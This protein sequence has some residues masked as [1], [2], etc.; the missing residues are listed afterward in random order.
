MVSRFKGIRYGL[1]FVVVMVSI[2][3]AGYL[4]HGDI[5]EK[6]E[7]AL[8]N[9][10]A[11]HRLEEVYLHLDRDVVLPGE[12]LW[13]K[14]YLFNAPVGEDQKNSGILTL[15]LWNRE[16]G[17][18]LT[19][20]Y[21]MEEDAAA[22]QLNIPDTLSSGTY[23]L[24]AYT[25]AMKSSPGGSFYKRRLY[26]QGNARRL[27]MEI[28][29]SDT[30]YEPG[31]EADAKIFV[32]NRYDQKIRQAKVQYRVEAAGK[33][34]EKGE[35]STNEE[36]FMR[37]A[38][39]LPEDTALHP[40]VLYAYAHMAG[41]RYGSS[42][43]VPS[44]TLDRDIQFFPES[45][46]LLKGV[47]N[48]VAFKATGHF[49]HPIGVAGE[50]MD[51]KGN[52]VRRFESGHA[53]TG[54]FNLPGSNRDLKIRITEPY[55][56][57]RFFELPDP[58]K[59]GCQINLKENGQERVTVQL[60]AAGNF[61]GKDL[62]LIAHMDGQVQWS[63]SFTGS[64][65]QKLTIPTRDLPMGVLTLTV[66][67]SRLI[68]LAERLVFVNKHKRLFVEVTADKSAYG[69]KEKV[70]LD[71]K[72]T[73]RQGNPS[74][75][76]LSMGVINSTRMANTRSFP[77]MP[78]YR[79]LNREIRGELRNPDAYLDFTAEADT[80]L[81]YLL[82]TQ[83]WRRYHYKQMLSNVRQ[84]KKDRP[85]ITGRVLK[86]KNRGA[87]DAT[88]ELFTPRFKIRKE[89]LIKL[90]ESEHTPAQLNNPRY[91]RYVQVATDRKGFF[92]ISA[93]Q[94]KEVIDTGKVM[95]RAAGTNG[96]GEVRI[97]LNPSA[98][99]KKV[100][101]AAPG[102]KDAS[103]PLSP[104]PAGHLQ[105]PDGQKV[106]RN[107]SGRVF[108]SAGGMVD[109]IQVTLPDASAENNGGSSS[110]RK[111]SKGSMDKE[112]SDIKSFEGLV[113]HISTC[114][115]I[116]G[117]RIFLRGYNSVK[118]NSQGATVVVDGFSL[119][120]DLGHNL[121][122]INNWLSNK[123]IKHV[124]VIN[125]P[126]SAM[127][128]VS[129]KQAQGG[130]VIIE[131]EKD[132]R[133]TISSGAGVNGQ[134]LVTIEGYTI[135]KEFYSPDYGKAKDE[136]EKL[137]LRSTLYWNPRIVIDDSGR[138]TVTFYTSDVAMNVLVTINGRKGM[139][140]GSASESFQVR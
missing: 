81:D 30:L 125:N 74:P 54:V 129:G 116:R 128:Y 109:Q 104:F 21:R 140:L 105:D 36:G 119:G 6:V 40:V 26:V 113:Q 136:A 102:L 114:G 80:A 117:S 5:P 15:E 42:K 50:V 37:V 47:S 29:Y 99:S 87:E 112:V 49:G 17:Q 110:N 27:S 120:K 92:R 127:K 25:G 82:M 132:T 108:G 96:K 33:K 72:V 60:K 3:T 91:F 126:A 103:Q 98:K 14:A 22:G 59:N 88:V 16:G 55:K 131:T 51:E 24:V 4:P 11:S 2:L 56:N 53:G 64:Q 20:Y 89:M 57:P 43:A 18:M 38:H 65:E 13:F 68:P 121:S 118:C 139:K 76:E 46:N 83:G 62:T 106:N 12:T 122:G 7:K 75:A 45:G 77:S 28:V 90:L 32:K 84:E 111:K 94:F 48:R 8:R 134:D 85:F 41:Q 86:S 66:F 115:Q 63:Q 71:I 70:K 124:E 123:K 39:S 19:H 67:D 135:A 138:G 100:G 1:P 97:E 9:H 73:D 61:L 95:V 93:D 34:V 69:K 23:T 101:V 78:A 79:H 130:V 58:V 107:T 10:H 52:V 31:Q 44:T 137:D 133:R 35:G